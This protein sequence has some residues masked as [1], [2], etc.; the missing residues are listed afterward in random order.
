MDSIG[1]RVIFLISDPSNSYTE[2]SESRDQ[3]P[4][5][6]VLT[7]PLT[8]QVFHYSVASR[9]TKKCTQLT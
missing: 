1:G 4:L 8:D 7:D 2:M 9:Q 6:R 5:E 3:R